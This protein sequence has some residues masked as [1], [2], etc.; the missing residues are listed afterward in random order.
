MRRHWSVEHGLRD[1]T[2]PSASILCLHTSFGISFSSHIQHMHL[3]PLARLLHSDGVP[4]HIRFIRSSWLFSEVHRPSTAFFFNMIPQGSATLYFPC[5]DNITFGAFR[6]ACFA[7][8]QRTA[9][10]KPSYTSH[11]AS[12]H[13]AQGNSTWSRLDRTGQENEEVPNDIDVSMN[14]RS[15]RFRF[16]M[17]AWV[18]E[19]MPTSQQASPAHIQASNRHGIADMTD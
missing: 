4:H 11:S 8:A 12:T 19:S 15:L 2:N 7:D 14:M 17:H 3:S 16:I 18:H 5:R 13:L 1:Q 10:T 9:I 6:P